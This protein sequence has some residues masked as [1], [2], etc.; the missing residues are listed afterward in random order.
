MKFFVIV[1][2]REVYNKSPPASGNSCWRDY[3]TVLDV[4]RQRLP[5]PS[6]ST[7]RPCIATDH[8]I[9]DLVEV[10]MVADQALLLALQ[11]RY[12]ASG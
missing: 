4:A 6:Q 12:R 11:L 2:S 3:A 8:V 10:C 9:P 5:V 7:T 1:K